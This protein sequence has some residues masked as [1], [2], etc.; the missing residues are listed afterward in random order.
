MKYASYGWIIDTDHINGGHRDGTMG[1]RDIS[2]DVELR[3]EKNKKC[4]SRFRMYDD[5][6]ELYY[7]GRILIADDADGETAFAPLDDFGT[8]D[9]GCTEIRYLDDAGK[10]VTL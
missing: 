2:P 4:G 8:P 1:P 6:G 5:D 3:L 10:W 7:S 9:A